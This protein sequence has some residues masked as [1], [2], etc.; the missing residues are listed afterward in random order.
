LAAAHAEKVVHRDVKPANILLVSGSDEVRMVDFGLAGPKTLKNRE[1]TPLYMSPEACQGKRIDEKSDV[2]ALGICLY[3]MLTGELPFTGKS[4]RQILAAHVK[5]EFVPV[6]KRAPDVGSAYD[7]LI[8]KMLV[9]AKGYR[10]SASDVVD[11]LA[12]LTASG[13]DRDKKKGGGRG[14]RAARPAKKDGPPMGI[15]IAGVAAVIIIAAAALI[16]SRGDDETSSNGEAPPTNTAS[17][18]G[19]VGGT[20]DPPPVTPKKDP[21]EDAFKNGEVFAAANHGNWD[22]IAKHW[23]EMALAHPGSEWAD[24]AREKATEAD[25][26]KKQEEEIAAAKAKREQAEAKATEKRKPMNE[27]LEVYDFVKAAQLSDQPG[28]TNL[29]GETIQDW[30]RRK[31]RIQYLADEFLKRFNEGIDGREYT[32]DY[33]KEDAGHD[34]IMVEAD[35]EGVATQAGGLPRRIHWKRVSAEKLNDFVKKKLVRSNLEDYLFRAILG[36]ETGLDGKWKMLF[37]E[38]GLVEDERLV[39]D[40]FREYF[41]I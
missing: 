29:P 3:Q 6:S 14:R 16:M 21:G 4:V 41:D 20:G 25:A 26:R 10:P 18:I 30:R 9:G 2:Y 22:A 1:G 19:G 35:A 12:P 28:V 36:E 7:D 13:T 17:G 32:A 15:V 37:E 5:G 34:E 23:R 40:R 31:R 24:K 8:K 38:A 39:R 11:A 27:A 33:L